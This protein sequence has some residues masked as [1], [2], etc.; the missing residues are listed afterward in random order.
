MIA[1]SPLLL[2]LNYTDTCYVIIN[3]EQLN[4]LERLKTSV[5]GLCLAFANMTTFLNFEKK[6]QV[7]VSYTTSEY[8]PI[9]PYMK[10][11]STTCEVCDCDLRVQVNLKYRNQ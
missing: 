3:D 6:T 7:K 10:L 9:V 4:K 8:L 5:F 11:A 1:E 2:I